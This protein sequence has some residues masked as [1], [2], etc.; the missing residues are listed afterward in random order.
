MSTVTV[1]P[2]TAVNNHKHFENFLRYL[3][4][5][6]A[7]PGDRVVV[8]PNGKPKNMDADELKSAKTKVRGFVTWYT[9][10]VAK[11]PKGAWKAMCKNVGRNIVEVTE[12]AAELGDED[13]DELWQA[14]VESA[15]ESKLAMPLCAVAHRN[16]EGRPDHIH[17]L[18]IC[19][20]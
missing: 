2:A 14:F 9:E 15:R 1:S 20:Q 12:D 18:W 10:K 11:Q 7:T 6:G 19:K 16:Q 13:F 4:E 17:M 8:G 3:F 5:G